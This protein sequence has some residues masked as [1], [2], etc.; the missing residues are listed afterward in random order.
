MALKYK[1][2]NQS[3]YNFFFRKIDID[4]KNCRHKQITIAFPSSVVFDLITV[5][6]DRR[7]ATSITYH[8]EKAFSE[9]RDNGLYINA[10]PLG[11][12]NYIDSRNFILA[13]VIGGLFSIF[14][15]LL[16]SFISEYNERRKK[17]IRYDGE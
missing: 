6:P 8:S 5:E 14:A 9:L 3:N 2:R 12:R 10:R 7:T 4:I 11:S 16:I 13:T 15:D 17:V 1:I